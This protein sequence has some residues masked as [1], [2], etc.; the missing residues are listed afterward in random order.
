M[1]KNKTFIAFTC[2]LGLFMG[3]SS[4][5]KAEDAPTDL[6][7]RYSGSSIFAVPTGKCTSSVFLIQ[8]L[9]AIHQSFVI[10]KP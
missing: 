4:V 2:C 10:Q 9:P 6:R 7:F 8:I 5:V 3:L 1:N